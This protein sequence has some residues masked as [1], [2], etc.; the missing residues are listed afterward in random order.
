MYD[1]IVVG[2]R[3][4]GSPTAMLLARQGYRVLVVDKATFPSDTLS[5]HFICIS[6]VARLKRWGVLDKLVASKLP[7][8]ST[9]SLDLGP[10]ALRGM[11]PPVEDVATIYAPRRTVL[12]KILLDAAVAAGAEPREGFLVEEILRDGDR[13]TGI[14]GRLPD[15]RSVKEHSRLVIGADGMRSL[16]ARSVQAPTYQAKPALTCV[17]YGYW[18]GVPLEGA[19]IYIRPGRMFLTFPTHE[20]LA[21]IYMAWPH[22]EFHAVRAN[23]AGNFL[24]TLDLAPHFAERVRQ[25]KQEGRFVGTADLP[26]F[27]RKPYGP[28]WALVGDAGYHKDPYTAQGITDAFRDVELLAEAIDAGLSERRPL[29]EALA[30]YERQRNARALPLYEYNAQVASMKPLPPEMQQLFAA[31]QGNQEQTN[32]FFGI[33][34]GTTSLSEFFSS[35]NVQQIMAAAGVGAAPGAP[36]DQ[37]YIRSLDKGK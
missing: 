33:P 1:A 36:A 4:A 30:D 25:G 34:E 3:C 19:E 13:V 29:E 28:G 20:Q 11:P 31:L 32:R 16:V 8:I 15:G 27:F 26:N 17:Y 10:F 24:Q 7:P 37:V 23:I 18:S 21:C 6:G 14:R 22:S 35:E 5:T 12:D 2:A 9:R